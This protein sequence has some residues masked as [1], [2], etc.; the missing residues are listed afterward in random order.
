MHTLEL[1]RGPHEKSINPTNPQGSAPSESTVETPYLQA[2]RLTR[3]ALRLHLLSMEEGAM[4]NRRFGA[5]TAGL[6]AGTLATFALAAR[7]QDSPSSPGKGGKGDVT[8]VGCLLSG[9]EENYGSP[10]QHSPGKHQHGHYILANTTVGTATSVPD[11]S[12]SNTGGE[13]IK[14][15]RMKKLDP[16]GVNVGQW[17]E[18]SGKLEKNQHEMHVKSFRAVPVVAPRAAEARPIPE[19]PSYVPLQP[20]PTVEAPAPAPAPIATTGV[21]KKARR[22]PKTASQLPLIELVG[23]LGFAGGL[24]LLVDRRRVTGH[25]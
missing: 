22:L 1:G 9:G 11:A 23:L 14:L 16:N 19:A 2:L 17:V 8:M 10:G 21:E 4:T 25:A 5:I 15:E 7:A 6:L 3:R 12:C 24:A 18:V 20:A 13:T